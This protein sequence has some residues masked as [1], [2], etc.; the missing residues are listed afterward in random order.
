MDSA[1]VWNA[2]SASTRTSEG[3]RR[4]R[5]SEGGGVE[6]VDILVSLCRLEPGS[7]DPDVGVRGF[8]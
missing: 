5:R 3:R 7:A 8:V 6:Q 2:S 1:A 4:Y